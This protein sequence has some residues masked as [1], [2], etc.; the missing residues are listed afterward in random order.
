MGKALM[1]EQ[2]VFA[3]SIREM[4][5]VLQSLEHRP[6]WTLEG[7]LY[8]K[9]KSIFKLMLN[10]TVIIET[11]LLEGSADKATLDATDRSQPIST[12]L[13]VALVDLFTTWQ[14]YPAAVTGHSR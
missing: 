1:Q 4:D 14:I 12:A 10:V 7:K 5:V 3:Q 9:R 6:P 11:L 8:S 2:P 13:Q